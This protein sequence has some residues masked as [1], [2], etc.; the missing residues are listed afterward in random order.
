M[1]I[2]DEFQQIGIGVD[3]NSFVATLKYMP[4]SFLPSIDPTGIP[5]AEIL[6]DP[7]K[8][9]IT[10]LNRQA[11]MV[12]HQAKSMDMMLKP[13]LAFFKEPEEVFLILVCEKNILPRVAAQ[14]DMIKS[15]GI[16]DPW[17][18]GHGYSIHKNSQ[19]VNPDPL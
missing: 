6:D 11:D 4:S 10:D 1:K 13:F 14:D 3:Y 2:S 9:D 17:F 16:E 19:N 5:L 8:R 12:G 18:A 7:R 15:A